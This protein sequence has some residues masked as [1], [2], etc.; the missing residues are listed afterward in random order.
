MA[1]YL[2]LTH[3]NKYATGMWIYPVFDD[4]TK[5]G[6]T[7]GRVAFLIALCSLIVG[8]AFLAKWIAEARTLC[9]FE[10]GRYTFV[11]EW[12]CVDGVL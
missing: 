1:L 4:V 5:A 8:F 11:T 10:V 3:V 6:G 12:A 7:A 9:F 2:T